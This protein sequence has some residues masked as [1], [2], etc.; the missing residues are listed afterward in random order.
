MVQKLKFVSFW[1]FIYVLLDF[2]KLFFN[3]PC[4]YSYIPHDTDGS[5]E[6]SDSKAVGI[7]D[8]KE[9][10]DCNIEDYHD[11]CHVISYGDDDDSS[12]GM[13]SMNCFI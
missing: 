12:N 8:L 11:E 7:K 5:V 9:N 3:Y 4:W 10:R 2:T 6:H 13:T 1:W